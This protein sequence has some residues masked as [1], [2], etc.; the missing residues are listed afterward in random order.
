[1]F[2]LIKKRI[3][4]ITTKLKTGLKVSVADKKQHDWNSNV[5]DTFFH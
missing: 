2:H 3:Q 1:M 5:L 4:E